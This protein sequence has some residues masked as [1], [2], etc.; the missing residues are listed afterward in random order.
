MNYGKAVK[1]V[2]T[3]HGLTQSELAERLSVGASHLSL[4]E[5]GKRQP[6]LRVLDEIAEALDVPP[7]LLTLLASDPE[8]IENHAD[9]QQIAELARS[10][11]ALL[12]SSGEQPMLPMKTRFKARK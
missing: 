1:I 7:H 11:L 4:I 10:L 2:R 9:P 8:E 5:A 3:A 12:V 6:S